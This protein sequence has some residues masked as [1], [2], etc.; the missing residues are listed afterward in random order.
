MAFESVRSAL[1]ALLDDDDFKLDTPRMKLAR[2]IAKELL[3]KSKVEGDGPDILQKRFEEFSCKLCGKLEQLASPTGSKRVSAQKEHLWR[4]FHFSRVTDLR[5]LWR[6]LFISVGIDGQFDPLLAEYVNEKLLLK[7]IKTVYVLDKPNG[8]TDQ[9]TL[10]VDALN[11]LRYT[12][13][14]VPFK[15][16]QK[17]KRAGCTHPCRQSFILCLTSMVQSEKEAEDCTYLEFTK[18][19]VCAIDRGGLFM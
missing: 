12:A 2:E 5:S 13:G 1:S 15:L 9:L 18:K 17:Y 16:L 8:T 19:W 14:Y 10:T 3:Q 6:D 7:F 11:A 4:S